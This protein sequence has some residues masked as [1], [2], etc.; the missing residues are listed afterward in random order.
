MQAE[1]ATPL[2]TPMIRLLGVAL[3]AFA[4]ELGQRVAAA[5]HPDI[6]LGHGCVFGNIDPGQGS[7]LTELAERANMTKQSVGEVTSDLEQLGY[8]ERV[9]D[10]SD[11][12]A[13]IIRLTP[14]GREAYLVGRQLIDDLEREWAE[15]Y[16][17][18]RLS[19]LRDALEAVTAE[20]LGALAVS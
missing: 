19:A 17:E 7:R 4:Q 9:P 12:R 11:G 2:H 18:E 8:V 14:Q 20:R 16:G 1:F 15:R 3:D 5:G 6:R 10:P 13:K